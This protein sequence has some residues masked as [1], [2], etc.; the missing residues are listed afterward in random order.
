[1]ANTSIS[2]QAETSLSKLRLKMLLEADSLGWLALVYLG[3]ITLAEAI[4]NLSVPQ[5]GLA[6]HGVILCVLLT[7]AAL[8]DKRVGR[9]FLFGLALAPLIRLLSL[10]MPLVK[11]PFVYWYLVVGAPLFLAAFVAAR[12]SGLQRG[13]LGLNARQ[14]LHSGRLPIQGL[15]G[16]SGL[17]LGYLE[18]WILTPDPLASALR[19]DLIWMPALI[20]LVFT[21]FLEELIF[22]GLM[23]YSALRALG[24][25]GLYYVA[26]VF[27]VLHIG[28]RSIPDL[29][30]VF[31]VAVY[32]GWVVQR[33]GTILGVT[34]AHGLTNIGLF[35]IFPFLV[36]Q[37]N[38]QAPT[39]QEIM[40][41]PV[42]A[43]MATPRA[44]FTLA[45]SHTPAIL[46][47]STPSPSPTQ[48]ASE[49][50]PAPSATQACTPPKGWAARIV[51]SGETAA[52][53]SAEYGI[54]LHSLLQANCLKKSDPFQAGMTIFLPPRI[55]TAI[56]YPSVTARPT[57]ITL[58]SAT[59]PPPIP[60]QRPLPSATLLPPTQAPT[61]ARATPTNPPLASDSPATPTM[62]ISTPAAPTPSLPA[63]PPTPTSPPTPIPTREPKP[64]FLPTLQLAP[65]TPPATQL[66]SNTIP[67]ESGS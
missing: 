43:W 51:K 40:A 10:S 48:R 52:K 58:P 67:N 15:V 27:A 62:A 9:R 21:G 24:L 59:M 2:Q 45:P 47:S 46:P 25:R 34:L 17:G 63:Q 35:L 18:Y 31:A 39:P 7:H 38:V 54:S 61:S 8:A 5:A 23:Q 37:P 53:L 11:F 60:T 32:F 28:Y 20:L 14:L 33:S 64:T 29:I 16:L 22:R 56:I 3:L 19:L 55:P 4:T 44:T 49:T 57:Q 65:P 12:V 6:L 66:S 13:M 26:A 50:P 42:K 41:P 30:F 36:G 1:M